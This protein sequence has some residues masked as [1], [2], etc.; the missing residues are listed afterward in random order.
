VLFAAGR[1]GNTE[2]LALDNAAVDV[3]ARGR[4]IVDDC[5][6]TTAPGIYAA[7]DVIGPPALAS[8]S[9]EQA[10]VAACHAFGIPFKQMVDP[11]TPAGVYSIPEAAAVGLT[12]QQAAAEGVEYEIGRARFVHN[13][14][15]VISGTTDGFIKLVFRR[16][17]RRLLGVHILGESATELV[18]HG[19][20]VLHFDGTI[21]Y[22]IQSV[23]NVPTLS[24]SY[25]Y[26]AYDG[27]QRLARRA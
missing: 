3:D 26:A 16:A 1:V 5:F 9:M 15:S 25:K 24:E 23:Y 19:Q 13:S 11:I 21:D 14:R 4:I 27:L 17:D 10:R 18:H 6:R 7:G 12:E 8:V 20:T 22:F 2:D